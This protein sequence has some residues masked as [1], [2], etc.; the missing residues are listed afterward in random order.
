V[1][2]RRVSPTQ[3]IT[4][5]A[6]DYQCV[7]VEDAWHAT[8]EQAS[9]PPIHAGGAWTICSAWAPFTRGYERR[10]PDCAFC[11]RACEKDEGIY[12]EPV[13]PQSPPAVTAKYLKALQPAPAIVAAA[14][15]PR[16][17]E[18]PA[19]AAIIEKRETVAAAE[20][21]FDA[22]LRALVDTTRRGRR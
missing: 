1:S 15:A 8:Q 17:T 11:L 14:A 10:R 16:T 20:A 12:V 22:R 4:G 3:G 21:D 7:R 2:R 9:P 13:V 18:A 6:R 19:A 5:A